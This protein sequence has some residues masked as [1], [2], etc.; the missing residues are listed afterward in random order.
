MVGDQF[1][2][3]HGGC[4]FPW[5]HGRVD[6][7]F[8]QTFGDRGQGHANRCAAQ[9]GQHVVDDTGRAAH[10]LA[11]HVLKAGDRIGRVDHAGA[12]DPCAQNLEVLIFAALE[13][14]FDHFP[15]GQRG[16]DRAGHHE[17]QFKHF[18]AREAAG[19]IADNGHCDVC[20]TV[21]R[22]IHQLWRAAAQRHRVKMLDV[23]TSTR[24]CCQT[25]APGL[26]DLGGHGGDG[27]QELV[28]PQCH[29]LGKSAR[30]NSRQCADGGS[31][32]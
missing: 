14:G 8:G 9:F 6:H 31:G 22:L 13:I 2:Q 3:A 18:A 24:S 17:R 27:R 26:E 15:K 10:G 7:A 21:A 29:V 25:F 4:D 20:H 23:Q 1:G 32:L 11:F 16:G 30:W 28:Q 19:R 5:D 12:V